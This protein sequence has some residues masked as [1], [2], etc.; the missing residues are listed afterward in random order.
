MLENFACSPTLWAIKRAGLQTVW[1]KKNLRWSLL[2]FTA[3]PLSTCWWC[4]GTLLSCCGL[5]RSLFFSASV[6]EGLSRLVNHVMRWEPVRGV[7]S[8][9]AS[10]SSACWDTYI[11]APLWAIS[12]VKLLKE[13]KKKKMNEGFWKQTDGVSR[14]CPWCWSSVLSS[15]CVV[16]L[17]YRADKLLT[18]WLFSCRASGLA[19]FPIFVLFPRQSQSS[20]VFFCTCISLMYQRIVAKW[21]ALLHKSRNVWDWIHLHVNMLLCMCYGGSILQ[22]KCYLDSYI[23]CNCYCYC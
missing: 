14:R 2:K 5:S 15:V 9:S 22:I 12:G 23:H 1:K 16:R 13:K 19:H 3:E 18:E 20:E 11:K 10:V 21:L 6:H 4:S 7:A 8:P 17:I